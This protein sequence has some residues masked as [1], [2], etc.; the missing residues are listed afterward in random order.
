MEGSSMMDAASATE[1]RR[2]GSWQFTLRGLFFLTF[3]VALGLSFW[4]MEQDWYPAVLAAASFWIVLGL[5][6][7]ARD[8]CCDLRGRC[9][10][11]KDELCGLGFAAAWRLTVCLLIGICLLVRAVARFHSC[12]VDRNFPSH[13]DFLDQECFILSP[14]TMWSAVLLCLLIVAIGY[15]RSRIRRSWRP[16]WS[17]TICIFRGVAIGVLFLVVLEERQVVAYLVHITIVGVLSAQPLLLEPD[18]VVA[19]SRSRIMLFYEITSAGVVSLLASSILLWQISVWWRTG[20]AR[21]L[22]LA[23]VLVAS[24]AAMILITAR[25][26]VVEIPAISPLMAANISMPAPI[27]FA[28]AMLLAVGLATAIARRWAEPLPDDAIPRKAT[29]RRDERR[30]YHERL[31]LILLLSGAAWLECVV[32]GCMLLRRWPSSWEEIACLFASPVETLSLALFLL[33]VQVALFGLRK[34]SDSLAITQPRITP[35]LF[36]VVWLAALA[37]M[38]CAAP[39]LSAW[40]FACFLKAGYPG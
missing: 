10:L 19:A 12:Y 22:C 4:K 8:I 9:D 30:Y 33:A 18:V 6:A 20:G 38:A 3:S 31:P 21:R 32:L 5:A 25:I 14:R 29:W 13:W 17:W 27:Q 35:A 40:H 15:S 16:P 37:I 34:R 23:A 7:Q 2:S 11:A 1:P 39:V 24:L 36:A 28:A 26:A